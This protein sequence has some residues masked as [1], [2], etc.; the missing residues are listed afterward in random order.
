MS[1]RPHRPVVGYILD[2][3]QTLTISELISVLYEVAAELCFRRDVREQNEDRRKE[4][5]RRNR[6]P[7]PPGDTDSE[8]DL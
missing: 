4:I 6:Q 7:L 1:D 3:I 8:T 5:E 2:Q